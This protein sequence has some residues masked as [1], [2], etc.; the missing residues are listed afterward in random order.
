MPKVIDKKT[1][2]Q[3]T[4]LKE[5]SN[6]SFVKI[7][8]KLDLHSNT[9]SRVYKKN[10]NKPVQQETKQVEVLPAVIPSSIKSVVDDRKRK[11]ESIR[12]NMFVVIE[13]VGDLIKDYTFGYEAEEMLQEVGLFTEEFVLNAKREAVIDFKIRHGFDRFQPEELGLVSD[14]L[15]QFWN[16][17]ISSEI[18]EGEAMEMLAYALENKERLIEEVSGLE[19]RK[20][21]LIRNIA[22]LGEKQGEMFQEIKKLQEEMEKME[23]FRLAKAYQLART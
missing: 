7:G 8:E 1:V 11:L 10:K 2:E 20:N 18:D 14:S 6:F 23:A 17:V 4:K 12:D 21:Q 19:N 22:F 16:E 13:E 3:I 9:V 5:E 15:C